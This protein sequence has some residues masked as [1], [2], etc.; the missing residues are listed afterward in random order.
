MSTHSFKRHERLK[1][2]KIITLLFDKGTT[3][4]V[5]SIELVW[6]YVSLPKNTLSQIAFSV[7]KKKHPLALV[8]NKLKRKMKESFRL[9][10]D[11]LYNY[12]INSKSSLVLMLIFKGREPL[13][14]SDVDVRIKS[15]LKKLIIAHEEKAKHSST[16]TGLDI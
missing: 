14:Y 16:N 15:L 7:P 11:K 12:L 13:N 10:K 1:S 8:R 6:L 4:R 5:D 3:I 9:N 2:K